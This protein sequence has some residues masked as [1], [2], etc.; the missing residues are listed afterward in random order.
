MLGTSS[1]DI[2]HGSDL[3]DSEIEDSEVE[4]SEVEE[5]SVTMS[6]KTKRY[7]PEATPTPAPRKR[8][9]SAQVSR[10]VNRKRPT[11]T[12]LAADACAAFKITKRTFLTPVIRHWSRRETNM[13]AIDVRVLVEGGPYE[14]TVLAHFGRSVMVPAK[15]KSRDEDIEEY[16]WEAVQEAIGS[17]RGMAERLL[18]SKDCTQKQFGPIVAKLHDPGVAF[19]WNSLRPELQ[20]AQVRKWIEEEGKGG[21]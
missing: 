8:P 14:M 2:P 1:E 7:A 20:A 3:E 5:L 19:L 16:E 13:A 15:L 9:H 4:E 18:K 17:F 6:R 11:L 10:A 21:K 12:S